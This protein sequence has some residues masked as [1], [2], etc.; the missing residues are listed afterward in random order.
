MNYTLTI[1]ISVF[2]KYSKTNL[3]FVIH[4]ML[5]NRAQTDQKHRPVSVV[6]HF[7]PIMLQ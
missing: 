4:L 2:Y 7:N 6:S 5:Q 1:I 3:Y